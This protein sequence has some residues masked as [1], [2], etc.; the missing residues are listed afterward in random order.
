MLKLIKLAVD[1][2]Y[3]WQ[4]SLRKYG[5]ICKAVLAQKFWEGIAPSAPSSSSLKKLQHITETRFVHLLCVTR[6][7]TWDSCTCKT[8]L[9]NKMKIGIKME[10]LAS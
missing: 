6:D 5:K 2:E 8:V 4:S 9:N 3:L 7:V 10:I 1:C